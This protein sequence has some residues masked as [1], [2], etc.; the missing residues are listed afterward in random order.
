MRKR[1]LYF[2]LAIFAMGTITAYGQTEGKGEGYTYKKFDNTFVVSVDNHQEVASTLA[3]VCND[4][5]ITGGDI[6]GIGAVNEATLRCFNPATKEYVDKTFSEQMEIANL[7]GNIG[8]LNGQI[9]LHL[10]VTLGKTDYT[11]LAGHLL[12]ATLNGAG[13]FVINKYSGE[14]PRYHNNQIG[15][16]MYRFCMD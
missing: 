5:N 9:Y 2:I 3:R 16:N 11:A 13:E 12:S 4:L 7:T 10:H 8:V 6:I 14:V 15:L 1:I